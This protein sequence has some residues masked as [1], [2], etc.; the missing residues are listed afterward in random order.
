MTRTICFRLECS[1]RFRGAMALALLLGG[2][3]PAAAQEVEANAEV[4]S[5]PSS[6]AAAW[7]PPAAEEA[8]RINERSDAPPRVRIGLRLTPFKKVVT[9]ARDGS[10]ETR[11]IPAEPLRHTLRARLNKTNHFFVGEWHVETVPTKWVR[12]SRRYEVRLNV[13]RRYGAFGQL[14][15]KLGFVDLAGVLDEQEDGLFV[16]IGVARKRL[17]D[18]FQNPSLDIVAGFSPPEKPREVAKGPASV[19][20][21]EPP[22][23]NSEAIL[24]GRF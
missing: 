20:I 12:K 8:K 17:R 14:E 4:S 18:K 23:G 15:E 11:Y 16:L 7:N 10:T 24:R 19:P 13:Y 21:P 3:V 1:W 9:K 5:Q 22:V 6:R 2:V